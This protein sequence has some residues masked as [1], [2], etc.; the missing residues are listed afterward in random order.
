MAMIENGNKIQNQESTGIM[1]KGLFIIN[2]G[3]GKGKTTAA[4][5]QAFRALG[6]QLNVCIIQFIKGSWKYG[7]LFSK[8]CF[9]G[10]LDFH[11]MG[12]GF[13]FLSENLEEDKKIARRGWEFARDVLASDKYFLVILDEIT[14]I[15]NYGF[16]DVNEVME[17]IQ[18]RR[19]DLHVVIT[20]RDAPQ[21][22]MDVADMVTLM[23]EIKHPFKSG[24]KAQKGIEF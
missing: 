2:T 21:A 14:Y 18:K 15:M 23:Q 1:K 24:V 7:E 6:H 3:N 19:K 12:R 8:D 5:G 9:Q 22:M 17:S 16:I 13:T 10:L 4:L 11:V 20:G